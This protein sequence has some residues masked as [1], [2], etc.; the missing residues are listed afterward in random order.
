MGHTKLALIDFSANFVCMW[1][2]RMK[3]TKPPLIHCFASPRQKQSNLEMTFTMEVTISKKCPSL[4][5]GHYTCVQYG[6]MLL[7]PTWH[8]LTIPRSGTFVSEFTTRRGNKRWWKSF[9]FVK[10]NIADSL[11]YYGFKLFLISH[12]PVFLDMQSQEHRKAV[13]PVFDILI[14]QIKAC[15]G[16]N[17]K[18]SH[19]EFSCHSRCVLLLNS[20]T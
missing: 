3:L 18:V 14:S 19:S 17:R 7:K 1:Q 15:T 10:L 13:M 6:M 12:I 9:K 20:C 2:S 11:Y 4:L 5:A 8:I 16:I